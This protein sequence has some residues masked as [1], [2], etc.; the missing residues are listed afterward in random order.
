MKTLSIIAVLF[1]LNATAADMFL[2]IEQRGFAVDG[3]SE[4]ALKVEALKSAVRQ[5]WSECT[6]GYRGQMDGNVCVTATDSSY[7]GGGGRA[8]SAGVQKA[9]VDIKVYC[10]ADRAQVSTLRKWFSEG[11]GS[12]FNDCRQH[13]SAQNLLN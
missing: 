5:A 2:V 3:G 12:A 6:E 8:R 10:R 9:S 7:V 4:A 11:D 13:V 1:S